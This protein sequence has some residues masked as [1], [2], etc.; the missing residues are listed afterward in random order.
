MVPCPRSMLVRAPAA[1]K[2]GMSVHRFKL[3]KGVDSSSRRLFGDPHRTPRAACTLCGPAPSGARRLGGPGSVSDAAVSRPPQLL[4][5]LFLLNC[6]CLPSALSSRQALNTF[7]R[8]HSL[9][10]LVILPPQKR[11]GPDRDKAM[12]APL[13]RNGRRGA[14]AQEYSR[15]GPSRG[16]VPARRASSLSRGSCV[17]PP[18]PGP[19]PGPGSRVS[20]FDGCGLLRVAAGPSRDLRHA[21]PTC[22]RGGRGVAARAPRSSSPRARGPGTWW[23]RDSRRPCPS[24]T[25][26][27]HSQRRDRLVPW[28]AGPPPAV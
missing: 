5:P 23:G 8:V 6:C 17:P 3:S 26:R 25:P 24:A 28:P 19:G 7:L 1:C 14:C 13:V 16:A 10:H 22:C 27:P 9:T 12:A 15:A 4:L 20:V 18:G 21:A 11:H 2:R